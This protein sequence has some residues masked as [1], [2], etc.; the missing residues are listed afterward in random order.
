MEKTEQS[1]EGIRGRGR[2]AGAKNG[3]M[4]EI[5]LYG[6]FSHSLDAAIF[7]FIKSKWI[8]GDLL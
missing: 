1:K 7:L 4:V 3:M 6:C 2:E 8:W 5:G